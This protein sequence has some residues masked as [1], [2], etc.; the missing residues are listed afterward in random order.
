MNKLKEWKKKS[1]RKPLLLK[2]TH[3]VG[4]TYIL[5]AFGK[6]CFSRCHLVNF[7]KET[8]AARIFEKDLKPDRILRELA[9]YLN[10]KIDRE[11][12]V[13][14]F[15]EIQACPRAL[16]SLK[17]F[18]EDRPEMAL[19]AAGSLLGLKL[20]DGSF[21]VGKV[22][23]MTLYPMAFSGFLRAIGDD[24]SLDILENVTA[25]SEIPDIAHRHLWEQLKIYFVTGGLP[26]V[27][28][29][30]CRHQDDL[31]M[32]LREVREKQQEAH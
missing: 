18:A 14:I 2:G 11:T 15:D 1:F 25:A 27:V 21:P 10:T 9:F 32:A 20:A 6:Q 13:L 30:F 17:Y 23:M 4:K 28:A 12:D 3:Q 31:F 16:T 29:T 22:D 7:E 19:C 24:R 5:Q 8:E 26:E